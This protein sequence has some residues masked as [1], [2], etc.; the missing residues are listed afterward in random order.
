MSIRRS[1]YSG[2]KC[3]LLMLAYLV[4]GIILVRAMVQSPKEPKVK[5]DTDLGKHN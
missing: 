1:V 3:A 2:I 4:V 5:H